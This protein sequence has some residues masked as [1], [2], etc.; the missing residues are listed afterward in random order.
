M[1]LGWKLSKVD[2]DSIDNTYVDEILKN[3]IHKTF[4]I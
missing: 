1:M 2:L 3:N 4:K